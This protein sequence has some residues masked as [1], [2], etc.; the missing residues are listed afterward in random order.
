MFKT[1]PIYE[2]AETLEFKLSKTTETFYAAFAKLRAETGYVDSCGPPRSAA[3]TALP[4]AANWM[5]T[6]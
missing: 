2:E 5:D 1:T 6:D 4:T 3:S